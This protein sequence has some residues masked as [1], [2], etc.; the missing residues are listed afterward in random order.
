MWEQRRES[1]TDGLSIWMEM[2]WSSCVSRSELYVWYPLWRVDSSQSWSST[3]C[4]P[5]RMYTH[6]VDDGLSRFSAYMSLNLD[7]SPGHVGWGSEAKSQKVPISYPVSWMHVIFFFCLIR[8]SE[9]PFQTSGDRVFRQ[10]SVCFSHSSILIDYHHWTWS[11]IL[12][13]RMNY[14]IKFY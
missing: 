5:I 10:T 14:T 6:I 8:Y 12:A 2:T 7:I 1:F 3:H 11:T 13:V 9:G 4:I